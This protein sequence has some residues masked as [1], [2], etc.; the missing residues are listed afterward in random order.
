MHLWAGN[1]VVL[2][3][4]QEVMAG[5]S[6]SARRQHKGTRL[7]VQRGP[8]AMM[9]LHWG[10]CVD[11]YGM[12]GR[13]AS[14]PELSQEMQ[15]Q[16]GRLEVLTAVRGRSVSHDDVIRHATRGVDPQEKHRSFVL[17]KDEAVEDS[18]PR[19]PRRRRWRRWLL[20][21]RWRWLRPWTLRPQAAPA[22]LSV[23]AAAS[24]ASDV[25]VALLM[26]VV[27]KPGWAELPMA[28]ANV[29]QACWR[30]P[31]RSTAASARDC[32]ARGLLRTLMHCSPSSADARSIHPHAVSAIDEEESPRHVGQGR[33]HGFESPARPWTVNARHLFYEKKKM[34]PVHAHM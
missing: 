24:P 29:V 21:W 11:P 34:Q 27:S 33:S 20:R 15:T 32:A 4:D 10:A 30:A 14:L 23:D 2:G 7:P 5:H 17:P 12:Y 9:R 18:G 19:R 1:L 6:E 25:P 26:R 3:Y 16:E 22:V 31:T 28:S 8:V 13:A